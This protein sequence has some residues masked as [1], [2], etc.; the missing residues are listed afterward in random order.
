MKRRRP[1]AVPG[2]SLPG[3]LLLVVCGLTLA[4]L[5]AMAFLQFGIWGVL[6]FALVVAGLIILGLVVYLIV[7]WFSLRKAKHFEKQLSAS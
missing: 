7:R 4:S 5:G 1:S 6:I 2:M 3:L